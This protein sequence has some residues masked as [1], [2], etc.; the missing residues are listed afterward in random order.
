MAMPENG[1]WKFVHRHADPIMTI[2]SAE[3]VIQP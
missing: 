1:A 3:S 2:R